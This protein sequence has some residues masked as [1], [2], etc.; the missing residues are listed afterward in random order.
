MAL[1]DIFKKKSNVNGEIKYFGLESWWLEELTDIERKTILNKLFS[2]SSPT[3]LI[4]S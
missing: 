4:K 3:I 1:F 2:C